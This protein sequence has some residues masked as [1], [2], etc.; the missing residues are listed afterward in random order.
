[1]IIFMNEYEKLKRKGI[2]YT[3][4]GLFFLAVCLA[5]AQLITYLDFPASDLFAETALI[6][7]W[8]AVWR[9]VEIFLYELPELKQKLKGE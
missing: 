8:V 1:M 2:L 7:G 9:P 5:I 4:K 3:F 6:A